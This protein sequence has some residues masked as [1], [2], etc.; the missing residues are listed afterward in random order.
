M[1]VIEDNSVYEIDEDCIHRKKVPGECGT[2][3]K[4]QNKKKP[5]RQS[6]LSGMETNH[7]TPQ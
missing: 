3:E 5:C 7:R 1:L 6:P 2:Y 4:L